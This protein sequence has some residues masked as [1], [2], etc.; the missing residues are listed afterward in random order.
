MPR[1][2]PIQRCRAIGPMRGVSMSAIPHGEVV[3]DAEGGD[4]WTAPA[5]VTVATFE[6]WSGGAGG[7]NFAGT[8]KGGGGG[9]GGVYAR[10]DN[11][12]VVPGR[13]YNVQV[14]GGGLV[15]VSGEASTVEDSV[16]L[17]FICVGANS[18]GSGG[19]QPVDDIGGVNDGL[20]SIGDVVILGGSGGD[21]TANTIGS[22][23][24]GGGGAGSTGAGGAGGAP[25]VAD[26]GGAGGAAGAPDGGVG[27]AGG[28]LVP[29]VDGQNGVAP[30]GGGG[31]SDGGGA[32][33]GV[34]ASGMVRITW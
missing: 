23:G 28:S 1:I 27:G 33:A 5:G 4:T 34:G 16:E 6:V 18:G 3:F 12:T 14:G 11:A 20:E 31:G 21:S 13:I 25:G 30:G 32:N 2:N 15:N 10:L 29:A 9:A 19:L 26:P 7:A 22:A 24:G 8:T 17:V